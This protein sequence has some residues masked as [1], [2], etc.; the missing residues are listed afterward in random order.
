LKAERAWESN[1]EEGDKPGKGPGPGGGVCYRHI[2]L[3]ANN[4][5]KLASE[6]W[7]LASVE[8]MDYTLHGSC[9]KYHIEE[10]KNYMGIQVL[11]S[12][13]NEFREGRD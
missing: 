1:E 10:I 2:N 8:Q 12:R 4:E 11:K 3:M 13:R 9:G 7:K 5:W 6:G